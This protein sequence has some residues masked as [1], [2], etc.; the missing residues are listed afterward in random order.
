[1]INNMRPATHCS[2]SRCPD[3]KGGMMRRTGARHFPKGKPQ[4]VTSFLLP[5][6]H[7]LH[8]GEQGTVAS[9]RGIG[10][11]VVR[12]YTRRVVYVQVCS[13]TVFPSI[14]SQCH[15]EKV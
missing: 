4:D 14:Q 5:R 12:L 3:P 2:A 13:R 1:M 7:S 10:S 15:R 8:E 6:I 9:L 11:F